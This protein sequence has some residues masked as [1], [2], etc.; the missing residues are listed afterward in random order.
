VSARGFRR[1]YNGHEQVCCSKIDQGS[2]AGS[3]CAQLSAAFHSQ[4][5]PRMP[6]PCGDPRVPRHTD[7]ELFQK[8]LAVEEDHQ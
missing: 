6:T 3:D 2:M 5:P 1:W 8:E 7:V 4:K